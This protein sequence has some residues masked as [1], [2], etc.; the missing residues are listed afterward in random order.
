M[1]ILK[2]FKNTAFKD[3]S[4]YLVGQI[5]VMGLGLISLP[6]FTKLLSKGEYGELALMQSMIAVITPILIIGV[7]GSLANVYLKKKSELSKFSGT[8]LLFLLF[9][10]VFFSLIFVCA[11]R[12]LALGLNMSV[13]TLT[14]GFIIAV[15]NVPFLLYN[16]LLTASR[17]SRQFATISFFQSF[18]TLLFSLGLIYTVCKNDKL[19]GRIWG[20][21]IAFFILSF[22]ALFQLIKRA[23]F[24]FVRKHIHFALKF[25]LPLLPHALSGVILAQFDRLMIGDINGKED[26]ALYSVAYN[27]GNL[28][29]VFAAALNKTWVPRFYDWVSSQNWGKIE[30]SAKTFNLIAI[31]VAIGMIFFSQEIFILLVDAKFHQSVGIVPLIVLSG[32]V[33]LLYLFYGNYSFYYE[34]TGLIAINTIS[35]GIC[36][37]SLNYWLIPLYGYEIAA[38]TTLISYLLLFVLHYLNAKYVLKANVISLAPLLKGGL[39]LLISYGIWY[40]IT[41]LPFDRI[42]VFFVKVAAFSL[43]SLFFYEKNKQNIKGIFR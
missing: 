15:L 24:C 9:S 34:K 6:I 19:D 30:E 23:K 22:W 43:I 3:T 13:Q 27:I 4:N 14:A 18:L 37:I 28:M 33:T 10:I 12:E 38:L 17:K 7:H 16:S 21:L 35:A 2:L 8:V 29:F 39:M 20:Q 5:L 31:V 40:L 36:N 26:T 11:H 41:L 42:V 25:G 32:Y 1:N